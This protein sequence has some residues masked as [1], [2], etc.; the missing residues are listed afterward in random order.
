MKTIYPVSW[1]E[2]NQHVVYVAF[3]RQAAVDFIANEQREWENE[4]AEYLEAM[5][6]AE[7]PLSIDE[8]PLVDNY[9]FTCQRKD[10]GL[11]FPW[12]GN[13]KPEVMAIYS[14]EY[15]AKRNREYIREM[16]MGG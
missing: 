8:L 3:T 6:G 4:N 5:G 11:L 16:S 2:G 9:G 15:Q 12:L 13:I 14:P 10:A 7:L 1:D